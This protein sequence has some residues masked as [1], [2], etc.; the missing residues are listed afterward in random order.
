H[1]LRRE[2][3]GEVP[4]AGGPSRSRAASRSHA[5]GRAGPAALAG[6]GGVDQQGRSLA[7]AELHADAAGLERGPS[8]R[9]RAPAWGNRRQPAS[10]FRCVPVI[11]DIEA[12]GVVAE[13]QQ[14]HI[15]HLR[16][17]GIGAALKAPAARE[18]T[19]PRD[20]IPV[21]ERVPQRRNGSMTSRAFTA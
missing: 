12:E 21:A 1:R 15:L 16:M 11:S 4:R 18:E 20:D 5:G 8:S 9:N 2:A 17:P 7:A 6:Q 3:V 19:T 13:R 10:L 14:T